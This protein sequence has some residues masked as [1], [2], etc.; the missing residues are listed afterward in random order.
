MESQKNITEET[1]SLK[2]VMR[3]GLLAKGLLLKGDTDVK[4]IV[5]CANKPTK[6]LLERVHKILLQKIEIVSPEIKYS[7]ILDKEAETIL[8]V[9]LTFNDVQPLITCRVLLTSPQV[10]GKLMS[11]IFPKAVFK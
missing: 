4:L 6:T 11:H 8:I 7:V 10:R 1:R 3:V 5:I 9:R 2:G